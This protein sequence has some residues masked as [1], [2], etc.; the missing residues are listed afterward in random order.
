MKIINNHTKFI[1]YLYFITITIYWFTIVNRSEGITAYPILLFGIP[2]LWQLIK[3]NKKLNFILGISFV[4]LSSYMILA[5]LSDFFNFI[6]FSSNMGYFARKTLAAMNFPTLDTIRSHETLKRH[7]RLRDLVSD[8]LAFD[9]GVR[10]TMEETHQTAM[11]F[12]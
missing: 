6:S 8:M 3:P 11:N 12:F 4:C 10:P 7:P 2:F 9:P 5:Y 1:P